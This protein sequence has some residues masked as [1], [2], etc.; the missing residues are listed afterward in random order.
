MTPPHDIISDLPAEQHIRDGLLDLQGGKTS[1]ASCLVRIAS[2]RL[3]KAGILKEP[4]ALMD[5]ND[6]LTLYQLL[7]SHG[8][9]AYS[10]YNSLLRELSSFERA[11]DQRLFQIAATSSKVM[12]SQGKRPHTES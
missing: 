11:L 3:L 7:A 9:R 10:I 2:P 4:I 8:D 12:A 6:E 1:I 5:Q